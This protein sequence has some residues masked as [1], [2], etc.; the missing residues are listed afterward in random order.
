M[1]V[2]SIREDRPLFPNPLDEPIL[3]RRY[4]KRWVKEELEGIDAINRK[5]AEDIARL[6][7]PQM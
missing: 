4:I 6:N 2:I 7:N 3:Y 5:Q 1:T